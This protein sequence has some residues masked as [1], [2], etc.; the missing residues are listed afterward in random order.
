MSCSSS[1]SSH[2]FCN[3]PGHR[4]DPARVRDI[5]VEI[6]ATPLEPPDRSTSR[7]SAFISYTA[8]C[9]PRGLA[10]REISGNPPVPS[11]VPTATRRGRPDPQVGGRACLVSN[12]ERRSAHDSTPIYE[13]GGARSV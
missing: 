9:T 12:D 10:E 11:P 8:D 13:S 5:K 7:L 1:P 6:P 3:P 4:Q 2:P